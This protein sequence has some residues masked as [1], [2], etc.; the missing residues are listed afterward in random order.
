[1]KKCR[2]LGFD[3]LVRPDKNR[4]EQKYFKVSYFYTSTIKNTS[5]EKNNP[6]ISNSPIFQLPKFSTNKKPEPI[7]QAVVFGVL[8]P[9]MKA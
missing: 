9:F 3:F 5:Y 7:L 1:M 2:W 4:D 8:K 6:N